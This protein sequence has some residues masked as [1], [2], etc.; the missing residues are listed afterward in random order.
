MLRIF[1]LGQARSAFFLTG[2]SKYP[3]SVCRL[4]FRLIQRRHDHDHYVA[5]SPIHIRATGVLRE[6]VAAV[7]PCSRFC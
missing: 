6:S 5:D 1:E 4:A 2:L 3:D 7:R